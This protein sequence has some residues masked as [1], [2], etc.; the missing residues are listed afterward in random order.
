[1]NGEEKGPGGGEITATS[2]RPG[3]RGRWLDWRQVGMLYRRE[4]RA[5]FR[6]RA[7]VI[8]SILLPL[9]L[10][11]FILWAAFTGILFVMGQTEGAHSRV[12]VNH[13]PRGHPALQRSFER[14]NKLQLIAMNDKAAELRE[15]TNG[16]LDAL[17]EFLPARGTNAALAGNFQ[18]R[19]LFNESKERSGKAR[20]RVAGLIE[21]YRADW[22]DRE[23]RR[24][25]IAPARW[26]WFTISPQNVAS[27]KQMGAFMLGLLLPLTF[28]VMV[29]V[30]CFYPAV[31]A[32]AGERERNTWETLMSTA[33]DRTSIVTAKYLYVTTLGGLAGGLNLLAM[34]LTVK[35]IFGQ[36]LGRIGDV[37]QFSVPIA[38]LPVLAVA[39]VLLAGFV[40][41]GMMIF[42]SFAR[43]FRE[44][45]AMITPFYLLVLLPILFL[46]APGLKFSL[47]LA[48]V[49]IANVTLMVRAAIAGGLGWPQVGITLVVSLVLIALS[50]WLATFILQFEDVVT[51]SFQ[52]GLRRFLQQRL[53]RRTKSHAPFAEG[54][55]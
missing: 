44:G 41:A 47:P 5:A 19:I 10:Y 20:Q 31:D 36:L 7:I 21:R 46:Q 50:I 45:Q 33:A 15:I 43:T 23:A 26:R 39:S 17:V 30:G 9:F 27:K 2:R 32:T 49:P 37:V 40:A 4:L 25:D 53:V 13:W 1:M 35:P 22:L 48:F 34:V 14:D 51:G 18:A 54:R 28:V 3:G 29:A 8:N 52:G 24:L 11:P 38:A 42:A 16:T 55:R 12:V 6:E